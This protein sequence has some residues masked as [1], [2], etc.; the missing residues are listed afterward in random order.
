MAGTLTPAELRSSGAAPLAAGTEAAARVADVLLLFVN[1]P[2]TRGV[3]EIARELGLSKAVVHR[4]LQSLVAKSLMQVDAVNREYR[5]GPGSLTLG[6]RAARD[7]DLARAA[8]PILSRLRDIT[9][10]TATFTE[11]TFPTRVYRQQIESTQEI[12]MTVEI[13]R[14]YPLYA[15]A[16]GRAILAFMT[17][18]AVDRVIA[19]D[20]SPLTE[21]T[22][23]AA[24]ELRRDLAEVRQS[25][26][27][28]SRGERHR[29]AAS[30]AAPVFGADGSV[31]GAISVCGPLSRFESSVFYR[32]APLVMT[33]ATEL[34]RSFGYA[35]EDHSHDGDSAV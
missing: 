27:A 24:S 18:E 2:T 35:P 17:P 8:Q 5:L 12:K 1:G 16:S 22:I 31:R 11:L 34:S 6:A 13:G 15:G 19:M 14:P 30:V 26:H 23:T 3:S 33:A 25:G 7:L 9:D 21:V 10:E 28:I 4:I 32:Y 29:G 20:L